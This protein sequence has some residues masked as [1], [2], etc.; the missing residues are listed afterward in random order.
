MPS[1]FERS[2]GEGFARLHPAIRRRFAIC[3][4]GGIA[5]IGQGVMDI[6]VHPMARFPVLRLAARRHAALD[7]GGLQIPFTIE[8][9]AY[10]DAAGRDTYATIR[11]FQFPDRVRRFDTSTVYR[12]DTETLRDLMGTHQQ[13]AVD[14]QVEAAANGGIILRTGIQR[15]CTPLGI[16]RLPFPMSGHAWEWVEPSGGTHHI[17]VEVHMP[18]FGKMISYRGQFTAETVSIASQAIPDYAYPRR[19]ESRLR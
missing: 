14:L 10:I 15:L 9:Y 11:S 7:R 5:S 3:S 6:W 18:P 19:V 13:L 4:G 16:V 12:E 17:E 8:N 2:M 1:I